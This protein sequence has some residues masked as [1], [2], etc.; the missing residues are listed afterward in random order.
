MYIVGQIL[1]S[2]EALADLYMKHRDEFLAWAANH[3]KLERDVALDIYQASILA[4]YENAA[5]GKLTEL[6]STVKTYLFAIGKNKI[7]QTF[8][9][10]QKVQSL[11]EDFDILEENEE[12]AD[13]AL[14]KLAISCLSELG[15]PCRS[16]LEQFYYHGGTM[17]YIANKFGYKNEDAVKSQKYKCVIRLRKLFLSKQEVKLKRV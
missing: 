12:I 2:R 5:S 13:P 4:L 6:T 11:D 3:Y 14:L 8:Q 9:S 10:R 1:L 15:E 17:A 7:R 16:L